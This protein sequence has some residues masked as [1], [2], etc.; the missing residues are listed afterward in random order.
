[1]RN[2]N[3]LTKEQL[4]KGGRIGRFCR[5]VAQEV[6]EDTLL[7]IMQDCDRYDKLYS[8]QKAVWWKNAICHLEEK[9]GQDKAVKVMNSCGAKCCGNGQRKTAKKLMTDS[10]S[11]EDFLNKLSKYEVKDGELE[12]KLIDS[13]TIIGKHNRCFC[14]QVRHSKELFE[15]ATYCQCSVEFNKQFFQAALGKPVEVKLARSILNGDNW[16]EFII[17]IIE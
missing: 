5:I 11:I 12:Y 7:Y 6:S 2:N 8:E 17:T 9:V 10:T 13:H 4:P 1:M 16:C 3:T 15:T 14:G